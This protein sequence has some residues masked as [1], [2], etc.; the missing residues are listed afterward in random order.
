MSEFLDW[1][2]ILIF[3][4]V[5]LFFY[6]LFAASFRAVFLLH[7]PMQKREKMVV[8]R[9]GVF[10]APVMEPRWTRVSRRS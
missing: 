3:L 8:S 2:I 5:F 7:L 9:S 6:G 4:G 1:A 10:T